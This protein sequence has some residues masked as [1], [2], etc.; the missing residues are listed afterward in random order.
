MDRHSSGALFLGCF[1]G[2]GRR[3][4]VALLGMQFRSLGV[5]MNCVLIVSGSQVCE[6]RSLFVPLGLVVIS[7]PLRNGSPLMMTSAPW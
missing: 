7:L 2:S 4:A 6:V 1:L 3:Q 5:V